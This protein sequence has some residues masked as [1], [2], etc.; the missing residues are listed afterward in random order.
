MPTNDVF[1]TAKEIPQDLLKGIQEPLITR[2]W[3]TALFACKARRYL[4]FFIKMAKGVRNMTTTKEKENTIALNLLS[5]ASSDWVVADVILIASL[6]QLFLNN[7]MKWYQGVDP[8]IGRSG[9]LTFHCA[10][11]YFLMLEDFTR[12]QKVL[13]DPR[14]FQ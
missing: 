4:P 6:S 11:R 7:H 8:N 10:V 5:L 12:S 13:G 9:F 3:T 14:A 2:W 1:N